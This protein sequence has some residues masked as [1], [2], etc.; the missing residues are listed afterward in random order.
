MVVSPK[1][2]LWGP[3]I[4]IVVL[5]LLF[6]S[7]IGSAEGVAGS[8]GVIGGGAIADLFNSGF[9]ALSLLTMPITVGSR[10]VGWKYGLLVLVVVL[11]TAHLTTAIVAAVVYSPPSPFTLPLPSLIV[12]GGTCCMYR[13]TLF[14]ADSE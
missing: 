7:Q 4:A 2:R 14:G 3:G 12:V 11:A 13:K 8:R 5:S 6:L 10:P 1:S 9:A